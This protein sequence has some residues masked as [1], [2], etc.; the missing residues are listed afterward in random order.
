MKSFLSILSF[1][2]DWSLSLGMQVHW[3]FLAH[4]GEFLCAV[5]DGK[6]GAG[7]MATNRHGPQ[8][9]ETFVV[10]VFVV[11]LPLSDACP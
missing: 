10:E 6:E 11:R 8:R 4:T 3:A 2:N 9:W 7:R 5:P 1:S